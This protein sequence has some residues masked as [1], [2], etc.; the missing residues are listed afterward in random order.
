MRRALKHDE[1]RVRVLPLI[2]FGCAAQQCQ[3]PANTIRPCT[4]P[5]RTSLPMLSHTPAFQGL[6]FSPLGAI[7]PCPND[8]T[9]GPGS[10]S[11]Q[12]SPEH[13]WALPNQAHLLTS[14]LYQFQQSP[15]CPGPA[16]VSPSLSCFW[17]GCV[18]VQ[19]Q[20][21]ASL[22]LPVH[23]P[24]EAA[25]PHFSLVKRTTCKWVRKGSSKSSVIY[26]RGNNVCHYFLIQ[27]HRQLSNFFQI[28]DTSHAIF[29]MQAKF[30]VLLQSRIVFSLNMI[31]VN[32]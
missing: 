22:W 29:L 27:P 28:H 24:Q 8:W 30:R 6:H 32:L 20:A 31:S 12:P 4:A 2:L 7:T 10:I 13:P 23:D 14:F 15:R 18:C 21:R 25:S 9:A 16:Q 1:N 5:Y 19:G 26:L 11:P 3:G 17:M